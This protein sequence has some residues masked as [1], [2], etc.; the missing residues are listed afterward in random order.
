[1]R[2]IELRPNEL[3]SPRD[4]AA[5]EKLASPEVALPQTGLAAN[6][7]DLTTSPKTRAL[8]LERSGVRDARGSSHAP[9]KSAADKAV[10]KEARARDAELAMAEYRAEGRAML[11]KTERLRALR[12]AKAA[13]QAPP[14]EAPPAEK[15][16]KKKGRGKQRDKGR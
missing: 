2:H 14:A 1:M 10:T 15:K 9:A 8:Q 3:A 16:D 7:V 12:L 11:A 4:L 5:P 13:G 6:R